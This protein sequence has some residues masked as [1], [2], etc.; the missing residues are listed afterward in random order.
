MQ[1]SAVFA[2]RRVVTPLRWVAKVMSSAAPAYYGY[3]ICGGALAYGLSGDPMQ[4]LLYTCSTC[5]TL[6]LSSA[7]LSPSVG[8]ELE[9]W[10]AA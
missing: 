10:S 5:S 6:S 1:T 7:S 3:W 9:S 8:R 4:Y 2:R